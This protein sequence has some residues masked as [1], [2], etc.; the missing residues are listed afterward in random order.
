MDCGNG[1]LVLDDVATN[2]QLLVRTR[3]AQH[4]PDGGGAAETNEL[5][6]RD[7]TALGI[8]V[9]EKRFQRVRVLIE[10][11]N[12]EVG[13]GIASDRIL[14]PGFGAKRGAAWAGRGNWRSTAMRS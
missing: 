5:R 3:A 8:V 4:R 6:S 9:V 12:E 7:E 2:L 11:Q 10:D 1:V 13:V 14:W